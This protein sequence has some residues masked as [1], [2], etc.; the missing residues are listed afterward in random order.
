ML[1][2]EAWNLGTLGDKVILRLKSLITKIYGLL[3]T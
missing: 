2:R 3:L 1:L